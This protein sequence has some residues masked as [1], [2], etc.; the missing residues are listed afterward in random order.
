MGTN[1]ALRDTNMRQP[2]KWFTAGLQR[3]LYSSASCYSLA[4]RSIALKAMA[5]LQTLSS[6]GARAASLPCHELQGQLIKSSLLGLLCLIQA[7]SAISAGTSANAASIW[8]KS[9]SCWFFGCWFWFFLQ[10]LSLLLLPNGCCLSKR[11]NVQTVKGMMCCEDSK[12]GV[13][14]Q[15]EIMQPCLDKNI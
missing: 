9:D 15:G 3:S 4:S 11:G 13:V 1:Q 5:A 10:Y 6:P 14:K 12:S 8:A 7:H 2:E